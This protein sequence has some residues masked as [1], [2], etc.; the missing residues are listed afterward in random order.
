MYYLF[1]RFYKNEKEGL[2]IVI[3]KIIYCKIVVNIFCV[4][5]F[6]RYYSDDIGY[7]NIVVMLFCLLKY[8]I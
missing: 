5:S 1:I 7:V 2:R 4:V 6:R 3:I 8:L